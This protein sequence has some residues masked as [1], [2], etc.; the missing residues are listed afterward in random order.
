MATAPVLAVKAALYSVCQSLYPETTVD[1]AYGEPGAI[2]GSDIVLVRDA[3]VSVSRPVVQRFEHEV[4]IDVV[5][6]SFRFG[7]PEQQQIATEAANALM[8][9]L[10]DYL[11]GSNRLLGGA[12]RH[13]YLSDYQV[14]EGDDPDAQIKGRRCVLTATVTAYVRL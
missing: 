3:R 11:D 7:G 1:V 5:F 12:C 9:R 4:A 10:A 13:S 8:Q 2:N 6:D 14:E